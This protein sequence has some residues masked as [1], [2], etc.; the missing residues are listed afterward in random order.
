MECNR[1][2][3]VTHVAVLHHSSSLLVKY[4]TGHDRQQGWF[5]PNDDLHHLEHPEQAARRILKEHV[6]I[7]DS[8]LKLVEIESF[9]G[10]NGTWHL[11]FDYLAFPRT[12]KVSAG[13]MISEAKWFEITELPAGTEFAN[14]GWGRSMLAKY[15]LSKAPHAPTVS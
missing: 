3:L 11:V 7:D 14:H 6:G 15:A 2:T 1:H 9:V 12:M 13:P 10:N 4:A 8:T 5:L